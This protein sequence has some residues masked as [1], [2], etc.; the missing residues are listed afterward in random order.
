MLIP[1][2]I[3]KGDLLWMKM[4]HDTPNICSRHSLFGWKMSML[5]DVR[6]GRALGPKW[7]MELEYLRY[8]SLCDL[9]YWTRTLLK[10][11]LHDAFSTGWKL[12]K[13]LWEPK[14]IFNLK[15]ITYFI[16]ITKLYWQYCIYCHLVCGHF[17]I[18]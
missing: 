18:Y 5:R 14:Y 16:M 4:L 6:E 10:L 1:Q 9:G 15:L 12:K 3:I 11:G 8:C 17:W 2:H 7:G 13:C